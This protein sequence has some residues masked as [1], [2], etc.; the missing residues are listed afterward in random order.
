[1]SNWINGT[2]TTT[3]S[4]H[5]DMDSGISASAMFVPEDAPNCT[6]GDEEF[7]SLVAAGIFNT[8][9]DDLLEGMNE[10]FDFEEEEEGKKKRKKNVRGHCCPKSRRMGSFHS[11]QS[12][13]CLFS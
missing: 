10:G 11:F 3:T 7:A 9:E 1:M 13:F 4:G 8:E 6:F 2:T 12:F 5:D